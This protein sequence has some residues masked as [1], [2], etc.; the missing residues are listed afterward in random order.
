MLNACRR[1]IDRAN[2]GALQV[3]LALLC[4]FPQLAHAQN[5]RSS[6]GS[7]PTLEDGNGSQIPGGFMP[8]WRRAGEDHGIKFSLQDT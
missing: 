7:S 3:A 8:E 4:L 5:G 2:V 1:P 6:A